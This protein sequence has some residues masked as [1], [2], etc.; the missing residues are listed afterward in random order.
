MMKAG[1]IHKASGPDVLKVEEQPIPAVKS[2]WVLVRVRAFGLNRSELLTRQGHSP[3]VHFPRILGIEA[4]GEIAD[5]SDSDF[6]TG[7]TVATAMGGMLTSAMLRGKF[8]LEWR[9]DMRWPKQFAGGLLMGLGAAMVPGGNDELIFSGIPSLSLSASVA[10]GAIILGIA[11]AL[12][13]RLLSGQKIERVNCSGD[14]CK[15]D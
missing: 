6:A 1:V 11:V 13:V 3:N 14:V 10:Y 7:D 4:V 5:P 9:P 15:F 8:S 12:K 2:E